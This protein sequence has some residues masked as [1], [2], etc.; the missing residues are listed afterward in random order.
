MK[1]VNVPIIIKVRTRV[2]LAGWRGVSLRGVV[3]CGTD[4]FLFLSRDVQFRTI[5]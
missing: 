1:N 3:F 4:Q 2:T 5:H